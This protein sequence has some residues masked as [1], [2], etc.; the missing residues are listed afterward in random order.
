METEEY[1]Q[2][3]AAADKLKA[4]TLTNRAQHFVELPN[5][6]FESIKNSKENQ[7]IL[8]KNVSK[9]IQLSMAQ[10]ADGIFLR[11]I[12]FF[13]SPLLLQHNFIGRLF[14]EASYSGLQLRMMKKMQES[15]VRALGERVL[16][17]RLEIEQDYMKAAASFSQ[18]FNRDLLEKSIEL[19]EF[20]F[21][22]GKKNILY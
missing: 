6:G 4:E 10:V 21:K 18:I 2:A 1:R 5:L 8:L 17:T 14:A 9:L 11:K 13:N 20:K 12:H 22:P 19:G 7:A 15:V 3:A 16:E